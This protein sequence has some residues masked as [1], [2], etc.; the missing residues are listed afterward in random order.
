MVNDL[1]S[2]LVSTVTLTKVIVLSV[3]HKSGTLVQS[4]TG[5]FLTLVQISYYQHQIII[6]LCIFSLSSVSSG[7]DI[8]MVIPFVALSAS[9]HCNLLLIKVLHVYHMRIRICE[10]FAFNLEKVD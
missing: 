4:A 8:S 2:T 9:L 1:Q 6:K 7:R 10:D 5:D 3:H